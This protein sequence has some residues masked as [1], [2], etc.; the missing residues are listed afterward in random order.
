MIEKL[1]IANRGEI[2]CRIARTA[3]RMGV[4]TVAIH[5][6]ADAGAVHVAEADAAVGVDSYLNIPAIIDAARRMRADAVHPGYGF[7]AENADFAEACAAAGIVFVGPPASAIRAMGDKAA[8]R[9][10]MEQAGV[11]VMPGFG[12]AD[13]DAKKLGAAAS[14]IGYPVMIKPV[15]GGGGKGMRIVRKDA[16][17]GVAIKASRREAKGAFGDDR[18]LIEK[19]F[20]RPRH[21]EVQIFADARGSV[22]HL[23]E[24]DCSVQRRHQKII[25]EAPAPGLSAAQRG[26]IAKAAIEAARAVGYVGA[27]TVEFLLGADGAFYF[28]EMNTRLQVEHPVTELI[29]GL[30]LVEWQMRVAAGEPLPC[31]QDDFKRHGHAIEARL[32]AEDPVRDFVPSAGRIVHLRLPSDGAGVRVDAGIRQGDEIGVTYDPLL[33]KIIAWGENREMALARLRRALA[34][35]R[36]AGLTTNLDFL[37][38]V[39]AHKSFAAGGIDTS[40][41]DRHGAALLPRPIADDDDVWILACV[42]VVY[43]RQRDA[44]KRSNSPWDRRDGW[45]LNAASDQALT[46]RAGDTERAF[47]LRRTAAGFQVRWAD[48]AV[49]AQVEPLD[50]PELRL[51]VDGLQVRAAV[52]PDRAAVWLCTRD[53]TARF[54]IVDPLHRAYDG[55]ERS[56][57]DLRS[58]M[59]G[60]VVTVEVAAGDRVTRGQTLMTLEA[61]KMEHDITAPFDGRVAAIHYRPGDLVEEGADLA[62]IDADPED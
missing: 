22:V 34:E 4:A 25:E 11:P 51:G 49:D 42:G 56:A 44:E 47:T 19:Y 35:T 12:A 15:A 33:A 41:I 48:G 39:M 28:L 24:R 55:E 9:A 59:P 1:L 23:F 5:T 2:A 31:S 7:L 29:T 36:L 18:I 61:M 37:R 45:R 58:P 40:Y 10:L 3:R 57:G 60:R 43:R 30:D 8:A 6:Q 46:L 20:D 54:T 27:G 17:L 26:G 38:A 13:Q 62:R 52:V 53:R 14:E 21:I 32:Y 50:W 16:E